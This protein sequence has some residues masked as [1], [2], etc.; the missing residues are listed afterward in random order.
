MMTILDSLSIPYTQKFLQC[1]YFTVM[2]FVWIFRILNFTQKLLS[3][4]DFCAQQH[5]TEGFLFLLADGPL[6]QYQFSLVPQQKGHEQS[7]LEFA[8]Y[9]FT[10]K[11]IPP[12]LFV[13]VISSYSVVLLIYY[14]E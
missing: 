13:D 10:Y 7:F 2:Y 1:V 6:Y 8:M 9:D 12:N 4:G 11:R 14:G 5:G 3:S